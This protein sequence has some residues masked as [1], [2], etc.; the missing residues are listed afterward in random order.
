MRSSST[1]CIRERTRPSILHW[2]SYPLRRKR[3]PIRLDGSDVPRLG[4]TVAPASSVAGAGKNGVVVT[5]VDPKSAAAERGFKEGDVILEV[6]GK[7][8]AN[9]GDVRD[10]VK[11]ARADNKNSVL[12]R[13]RTGDASHYVAI[14]L[15][16][17]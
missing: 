9:P 11:S 2:V 4:L 16:N 12:M 13:V 8:V 1:S 15:G 7:N 10:A 14:P 17:G 6:A 3:T 5:G